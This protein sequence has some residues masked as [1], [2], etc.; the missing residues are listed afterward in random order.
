MDNG[1]LIMDNGKLIIEN[2]GRGKRNELG[3]LGC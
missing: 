3:G 1:E 2:W